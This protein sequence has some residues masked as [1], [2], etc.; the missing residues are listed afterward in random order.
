MNPQLELFISGQRHFKVFKKN[1]EEIFNEENI[2]VIIFTS[3]EDMYEKIC[4]EIQ[5]YP[6]K[7][8]TDKQLNEIIDLIDYMG[9]YDIIDNHVKIKLDIY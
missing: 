1:L 9:E 3:L 7:K 2:E 8:P 6:S 5:I 4:V